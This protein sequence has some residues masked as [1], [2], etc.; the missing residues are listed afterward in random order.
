MT[1]TGLT[2]SLPSL[3]VY[4]AGHRL[5]VARVHAMP[6]PTAPLP[7]VVKIE[8]FWNGAHQKLVEHSMRLERMAS[9]NHV[10]VAI[11]LN[12]PSPQPTSLIYEE[13]I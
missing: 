7:D 6:V 13:L 12:S 10:T 3:D 9:M 2:S 4:L 8:A 11:R 1:T 5:Q